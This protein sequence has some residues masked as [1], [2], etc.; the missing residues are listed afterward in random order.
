MPEPSL[1]FPLL[2]GAVLVLAGV[3]KGLHGPG[4]PTVAIGVLATRISPLQ[5]LTIGQLVRARL[6]ANTFRR[7]FLVG[8]L[9]LG[10]HLVGSTIARLA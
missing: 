7:W 10:L 8:I 3:L 5:A 4:L 6:D 9:L 1:S 2:V